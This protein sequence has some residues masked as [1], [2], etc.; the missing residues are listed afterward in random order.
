MKIK[1]L[2]L[3]KEER[4]KIKKEYFAS[5]KGKALKSKL[6]M[7]NISALGLF[8]CSIF[9]TIQTFINKTSYWNYIYSSCLVIIAI[10]FLVI[11]YN[12]RLKRINNYVI[13]KRK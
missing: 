12:L 8:L 6:R 9:I 13:E 5:P 11:S 1:Y 7:V 3:S 10:A 2:R 4:K